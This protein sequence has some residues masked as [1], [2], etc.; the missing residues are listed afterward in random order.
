MKNI[1]LK[2]KIKKIDEKYFFKTLKFFYL[3]LKRLKLK[4][5]NNKITRLPNKMEFGDL[6]RLKFFQSCQ[7]FLQVNRIDGVYFEFGCHEANT[8]RMALNTL[9]SYDKPNKVDKFFAFDSFEGMPEPEG[10]DKQKIWK[11]NMNV[12]SVEKFKK[13]IHKDLHRTEIIE[14]Y[15]ENSLKNF[16]TDINQKVV[17]C[18]IDCDYYSSTITVLNFLKKFISHGMILAF[19]DFNCYYADP[20]RGQRKAFGEFKDD[21]EKEFTFIDFFEIS[22]GG[23]SFICLENKKIGT[24]EK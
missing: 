3:I 19:D 6:E 10:I 13:I 4:I 21:L 15:F 22:T 17:L 24:D 11:K 5:K 20:K 12:T 7:Y 8:F 1:E 9:G 18:Y 23:K 14:G 2:E 16:K